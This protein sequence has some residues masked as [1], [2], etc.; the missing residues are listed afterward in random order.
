MNIDWR[1]K[2]PDSKELEKLWAPVRRA[3]PV[4]LD[5][6][7]GYGEFVNNIRCGMKFAMDMNPGARAHLRAGVCLKKGAGSLLWGRMCASSAAP[8]GTVGGRAQVV[9][10]HGETPFR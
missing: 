1:C 2:P 10:G 5:L 7:C 9:P 6:G 8:I 3:H 4:S